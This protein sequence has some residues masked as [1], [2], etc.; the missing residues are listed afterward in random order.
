MALVWLLFRIGAADGEPFVVIHRKAAAVHREGIDVFVIPVFELYR[1]LVAVQAVG[2]LLLHKLVFH[3]AAAFAVKGPGDDAVQPQI[4]GPGADYG[5]LAAATGGQT[6][7]H[8][9]DER[10]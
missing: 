4:A 2:A 6:K 8:S 1:H 3:G 9:E 5:V 7:D 10:L